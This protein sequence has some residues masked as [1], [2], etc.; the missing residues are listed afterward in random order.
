MFKQPEGVAPFIPKLGDYVTFEASDGTPLA[1]VVERIPDEGLTWFE[2]RGSDGGT[3]NRRY[4]E[5]G[6]T[7]G[8]TLEECK[9]KFDRVAFPG[10]VEACGT[11]KALA[12]GVEGFYCTRLHDHEGPCAA[13]PMV[14]TPLHEGH[15]RCWRCDR[16]IRD[17]MVGVSDHIEGCPGASIVKIEPSHAMS[18][19]M[20][21]SHDWR[22]I[23]HHRPNSH[24]PLEIDR[25]RFLGNIPVGRAP[26]KKDEATLKAL[27]DAHVREPRPAL[28][29]D[30]SLSLEDTARSLLFGLQIPDVD[31]ETPLRMV[32]ALRELVSGQREDLGK[33]L[34]T[35]PGV[36]TDN[37]IVV[38]RDMP[39]ASLCEHH[40]LP[41][42]GTITVAYL[43]SDRIVGLSK[44]PRLV[45][46]VTR[47]LQV[48]ERIGAMIADA[49]ME[50]VNA[51][52]V[53]VVVKAQH[54][55][56]TLRG[57]ECPGEMVTSTIRGVFQ[58]ESEHAARAE[59]LNL[60]S[61]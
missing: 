42:T 6:R 60:M 14:N 21:A 38:V 30:S 28:I 29:L 18:T 52:G 17:G 1:G 25:D 12:N 23:P 13:R 4:F 55:C 9:T 43:P 26:S 2:I 15:E 45:R 50:H 3:Y 34:K 36:A 49:L 19:T 57:V 33:L 7:D 16:V 31:E 53:M 22:T 59:V 48:Q 44:I 32:K 41:F 10:D 11:T 20:A 35:F 27:L 8:P 37:G 58:H 51:R 39:F 40:V 56:M 47:R 46:A 54:T 5:L 61:M 24:A